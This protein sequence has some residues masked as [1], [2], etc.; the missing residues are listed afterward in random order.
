[1]KAALLL[2]TLAQSAPKPGADM[3]RAVMSASEDACKAN[4]KLA[5]YYRYFY[6]PPEAG[7]EKEAR[8]AVLEKLRFY[9]AWPNWLSIN[10]DMAFLKKVSPSVYRLNFTHYGWLAE[11]WDKLVDAPE[12]W[13]HERNL[14]QK[15]KGDIPA[16]EVPAPQK[17][18]SGQKVWVFRSGFK[19]IPRH[20][21]EADEQF[22]KR[23]D[24][25]SWVGAGKGPGE[26]KPPQK[27]DAVDVAAPA[28][29][30]K[31]PETLPAGARWIGAKH[32]ADLV[33]ATQSQVPIV[34][35]DWFF[36]QTRQQQN[37][38]AGYY[39]FV[40]LKVK[41][42]NLKKA[43]F[44]KIIGAD[45]NVSRKFLKVKRAVVGKSTVARNNRGMELAGTLFEGIGGFTEDY[46]FS[47]DRKNSLRLLQGDARPDGGEG[48]GNSPNGLIFMVVINADDDILDAVPPD[49][50]SDRTSDS[51]DTQVHAG[52]CMGCH[53]EGYRPIGDWA[54]GIY[55]AQFR[56]ESPDVRLELELRAAYLSDLEKFVKK[57]NVT[58]TEALNKLDYKTPAEWSADFKRA[59]RWYELLDVDL[60][61]L[62]RWWSVTP[63]F[64]L[65]KFNA[66]V[67]RNKQGLAPRLDPALMALVQGMSIRIEWVEEL[68]SE[69]YRLLVHP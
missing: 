40:G 1:V 4:P 50:A 48:M 39:D 37:R 59:I 31:A 3:D 16:V 15:G 52:S 64:M 29:Q 20:E 32:Y 8:K 54:R 42:K 45:L 36:H 18:D 67:E 12:P 61:I 49:I 24:E 22:Y 65:E 51:P 58:Y 34:R 11:V 33:S 55:K 62:A 26:A 25:R 30:G 63:K 69:V 68:N 60:D 28:R 10:S 17:Q 46:K 2:L 66:E 47:I 35:G 38:V 19:E 23:V 56:L 5:T 57:G 21:V 44:L 9:L 53:V 6:F 27:R 7:D 13:F 14:A 43:D 41:G